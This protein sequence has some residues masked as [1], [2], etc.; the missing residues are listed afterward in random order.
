MTEEDLIIA[1][2]IGAVVYFAQAML[3]VAILNKAGFAGKWVFT[4]FA[5]VVAM[6][7]QFWLV[8]SGRLTPTEAVVLC[9]GFGLLPYL[10]LACKSWPVAAMNVTRPET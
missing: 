8:L 1:V 2:A 6:I 5:P 7:A 3:L 10:V 9:A 4:G